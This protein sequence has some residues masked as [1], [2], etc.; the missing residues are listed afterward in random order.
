MNQDG[1][2]MYVDGDQLHALG[3]RNIGNYVYRVRIVNLTP[4]SV[5]ET[6]VLF[7]TKEISV[8]SSPTKGLLACS[9]D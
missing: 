8:H 2:L 7:Y 6:K 5:T 9:C 3:G 4:N 1:N